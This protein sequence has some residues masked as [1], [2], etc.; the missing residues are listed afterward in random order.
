MEIRAES[1]SF[2]LFE[3]KMEKP[4]TRPFEILLNVTLTQLQAVKDE[5]KELEALILDFYRKTGKQNFIAEHFGITT[6]RQ[7]YIHA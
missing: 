5:K 3:N 2:I 4:I 7:G 1:I 6:Q